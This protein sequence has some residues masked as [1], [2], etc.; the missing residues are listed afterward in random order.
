MSMLPQR[1]G[2]HDGRRPGCTAKTEVNRA[3]RKVVPRQWWL[4]SFCVRCAK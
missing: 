2:L 3:L 4:Y 1:T